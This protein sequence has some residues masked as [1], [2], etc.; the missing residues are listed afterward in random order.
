MQQREQRFM[1]SPVKC[2]IV[3]VECCFLTQYLFI[4]VIVSSIYIL[5]GLLHTHFQLTLPRA[6]SFEWLRERIRWVMKEGDWTGEKNSVRKKIRVGEW[7]KHWIS[8][9]SGVF[10]FMHVKLP[11]P[12]PSGRITYSIHR[13]TGKCARMQRSVHCIST[14]K[15]SRQGMCNVIFLTSNCYCIIKKSL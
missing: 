8:V 4:F 6:G 15:I 1:I 3:P 2:A 12:Q 10:M 13:T 7:G 9:L 5:F 14:T 11:K